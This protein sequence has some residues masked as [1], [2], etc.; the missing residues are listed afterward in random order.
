MNQMI[1]NAAAAA[2]TTLILLPFLAGLAGL[3]GAARSWGLGDAGATLLTTIIALVS[4]L[5]WKR[6]IDRLARR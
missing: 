2:R 4:L 5:A 1:G 6:V 3:M